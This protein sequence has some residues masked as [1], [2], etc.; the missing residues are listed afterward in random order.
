MNPCTQPVVMNIVGPITLNVTGDV[1][2]IQGGGSPP[3]EPT[4]WDP[5]DK[6]A[7]VT[8]SNGNLTASSVD[9][10]EYG[11]VI[12]T[13]GHNSGKRYFEIP[14]AGTATPEDEEVTAALAFEG[15]SPNDGDTSGLYRITSNGFVYHGGDTP[16]NLGFSVA[17]GDSFIVYYNADTGKIWVGSSAEELPGDPEAGTGETFTI[18]ANTMIFPAGEIYASAPPTA[19]SATLATTAGSGTFAAWDDA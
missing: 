19:V 16:I 1:T 10:A 6:T 13:R 18:P 9:S 8:L 17:N 15:W 7:N 3:A 12:A 14:V 11:Y 4:T 2:I 5:A